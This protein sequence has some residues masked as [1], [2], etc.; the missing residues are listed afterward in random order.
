MSFKKLLNPEAQ[1][2]PGTT[3]AFYRS[4]KA[5]RT[6]WLPWQHRTPS[7]Q[8]AYNTACLCAA[9]FGHCTGDCEKHYFA[10]L[11]VKSLR[12]AV[13]ARH[14]EVGFDWVNV[15]PDFRHLHNSSTEFGRF[16]KEQRKR[17]YPQE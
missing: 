14:S 17:D 13:D 4:A 3:A 6:R 11:A 8:A 2:G 16:L 1:D 7:W 10:R 12:R 15:D 5:E 9:A